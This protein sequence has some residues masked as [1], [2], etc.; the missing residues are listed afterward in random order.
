MMALFSRKR[1]TTAEVTPPP[2]AI[3][4]AA[5]P[6]SGP[7]VR[8]IANTRRQESVEVWQRDAWYFYDSVGELRAPVTW[9]ANA[10]SQATP[11]AAELDPETGLITGPSDNADA[12]TAAAA[13]LGGAA[14]RAQLQQIIAVCWQVPGEAFVVIRPRGT[15]KGRTQ[16]DEWLVLS[17]DKVKVKGGQWQYTDPITSMPVTLGSTDRLIRVWSPHPNDQAKADSAVRPAL[18]VLREIEKS[19]MNIASRLDSRLVGNGIL[20]I[21]QEMDF[22]RG[23]YDSMAESFTAALMDAMEASMASP[24]TAAAQAPIAIEMPR[25][26]IS[27]LKDGW[28]DMSTAFDASVVDLRAAALSRLAATLDMP[29]EVAEGTTGEANHWSAWQVEE[30]TYK[31]FIEPLLQRIG[32]ALTTHWF[33]PALIAMGVQN[34]ELYT[35]DWDTSAIV[36]SPDRTNDLERLHD[37]NLISDDYLRAESGIPDDAIPSEDEHRRRLLTEIV[38]AAPTL[39]SDPVV[40][41]ELLGIEIAPAAAGVDPVAVEGADAVRDQ[42]EAQVRALPARPEEAPE[43]EDVPPGLTAAAELLVKDAL[44][45]AGGRLLTRE[46]RGQFASTPKAEL[47]M[48][49]PHTPADALRLL[50]GSFEFADDVAG[51]FGLDSDRLRSV[52]KSYT[53]A[54]LDMSQPHDRA[55]LVGHMKRYL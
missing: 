4:A 45:R 47:Y 35:L 11:Y 23:E 55:A 32:D 50:E 44:S 12:Q 46:Y 48:A 31:I 40:A 2:R 34:P 6:L 27:A 39:L 30:S 15:L 37:R 18:P 10:V 42:T 21:P 53:R 51:L 54:R 3:L 26:M 24:G 25:D 13:V 1:D 16:P 5:M 7:G 8:A 43:P 28:L 49:I 41:R 9:I 17:G 38:K 19:S 52:L 14:Q 33:R 20:P 36:A 29:K 22:P